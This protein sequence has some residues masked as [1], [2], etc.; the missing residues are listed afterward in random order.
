MPPPPMF[1]DSYIAR[2]DHFIHTDRT[3]LAYRSIESPFTKP[4]SYASA[5]IELLPLFTDS[6]LNLL[7]YTLQNGLIGYQAL[8]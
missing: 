2:L 3:A 1:S 7:L 4:S 8:Y 6:V 5:N